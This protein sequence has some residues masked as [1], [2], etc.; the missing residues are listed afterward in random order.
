MSK[1]PRT[2]DMTGHAPRLYHYVG[3]ESIRLRAATAAGGRRIDSRN[4]LGRWVLDHRDSPTADGLVAATYVIASDGGLDLADRRS[5]H[6]ACSRGQPVQSAGEIFFATGIVAVEEVSNLSTG[7]CPETE[8]WTAVAAALDRLEVPHPGRFT[9][10][11]TFRR[12]PACGERNLIKDAVFECALCGSD[13]P[14]QWN[15]A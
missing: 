3:P 15:F 14:R 10:E 4:Q 13:L 6:I 11:I 5:E 7:F 12:C 8:S 1:T 2:D 9:A